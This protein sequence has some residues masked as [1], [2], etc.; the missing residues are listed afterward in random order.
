MRN[1]GRTL[2]HLHKA[3]W[4]AESSEKYI[5][6]PQG[7]GQK[8]EYAGGYRKDLFGF[9]DVIAFGLAPGVTGVQ[10][11]SHGQ[12]SA[13]LRKYRRDRVV[14]EKIITFIRAGNRFVI[15]GW[16]KVQEPCKTRPGTRPRWRLT[17]R[18][19]EEDDLVP[20]AKDLVAMEKETNSRNAAGSE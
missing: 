1:S 18:G 4:Y 9:L 19:V 10:V 14:A 5:T 6:R 20:T 12:I 17:V 8:A 3:G 13:H 7:K 16:K 15:H 2:Q 11:T